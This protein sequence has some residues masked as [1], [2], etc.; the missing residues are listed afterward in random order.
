MEFEAED[1][2]EVDQAQY[3]HKKVRNQ[4]RRE[5]IDIVNDDKNFPTL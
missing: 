2:D 5:K 3:V 1:D 4:G